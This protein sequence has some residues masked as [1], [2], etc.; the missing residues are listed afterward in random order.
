MPRSTQWYTLVHVAIH[1]NE[2][3]KNSVPVYQC[4]GWYSKTKYLLIVSVQFD[5]GIVLKK[6]NFFSNLIL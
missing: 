2:Y 5:D 3:Y 6:F 1:T 4:F